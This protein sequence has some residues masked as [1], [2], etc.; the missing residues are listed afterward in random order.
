MATEVQ[1]Q[2]PLIVACHYCGVRLA[3]KDALIDTEGQIWCTD[4][5]REEEEG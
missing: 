4:C 1:L 5:V 3:L 2:L